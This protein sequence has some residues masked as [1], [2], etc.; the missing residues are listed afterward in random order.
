MVRKTASGRPAATGAARSR[1]RGTTTEILYDRVTGRS[2]EVT[3]G[4]PDR[5]DDRRRM[6]FSLHTN[7]RVRLQELCEQ[8][9]RNTGARVSSSMI[10]RGVLDALADANLDFSNCRSEADIQAVVR[11]HLSGS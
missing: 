11:S 6:T 3:I 1:H 9:R 4:P 10:V 7:Q 2:Q 8:I 5:T